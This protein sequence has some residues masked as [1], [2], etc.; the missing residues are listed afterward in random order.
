[1]AGRATHA[2]RILCDVPDKDRYTGVPDWGTEILIS[3]ELSVGKA[4]S[5]NR[6]KNQRRSTIGNRRYKFARI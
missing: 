3:Y 4:W 2:V 1:V 5:E 6:P